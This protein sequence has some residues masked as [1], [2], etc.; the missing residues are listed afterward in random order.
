MA[1]FFKGLAGGMQS[2]L[3]LGQQLRQRRMEDELAQAYAKPQE[4][5][6]YTPEQLKQIQGLQAAGGYDVQ[7]VPGAEGAAPTLRYSARQGA[8]YY[9]DMGQPEAPIDIAPQRV[10]RYGGQTVAGQFDPA[11]L[12]GLQMREAAG[13]LGRYG[14]VRGAAALEMQAE[15]FN[16]R[17]EDR[18]YQAK[19][20]PLEMQ[21]LEGSIAGQAQ[22]RDVAA[23]QL[24]GLGRAEEKEIGFNTAFDKINSTKYETPAER[25][26]AVLTAVSQYKGPEAAAQLQAN[27]STNERNNIL[28]QGAK[29]D[30]TIKQARMKGPVAA[31][32][33]IDELNDSFTLEVDGFK[34]TQVNKDGS[35]VP[36]LQGKNA[37]EFALLV[38]SRIKDGG[39]F[40]L[41]KFRQD[42]LTKNAQIAYYN[43]LA[44]KAA[45]EGGAAANQ[46]SGVQVGYSRDPKTGQPIQVMTALRFN[47]QSGNLESV[48]VPLDQNV[49]PA[50]ALDPKKIAEQAE[51]LVNTPV[52]PTNKNKD[53]PKHT[54]LTAQQAVVDQI[55]NQ[56]LG[57]PAGG[58]DLSP[59]AIAA[60][61]ARQEKQ[62]PAAAPAASAPVGLSLGQQPPS[63]AATARDARFEQNAQAATAM[64]EREQRA[65]NDPDIRALRVQLANMRSGDPRKTA[66]LNQQIIDLRQQRY[67]F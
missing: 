44:K 17:A 50:S 30:Q 48:Q 20:R 43:S 56:Y 51:S 11:Q 8:N 18:A 25:D 59:A 47:K 34:V 65:A 62:K 22:Q 40:E 32:K 6:D 1:D 16:A 13:V 36:F 21:Q 38:D 60:E 39:A 2:G 24:R 19:R 5:T 58:L 33:A 15:D 37:D 41:A 29:F 4:F 52:D 3:Q 26:A 63:A 67:G 28:T 45:S 23:A 27:Y 64:R 66:E 12:R 46:L 49:V 14:D 57:K 31:L 7:A 9:D 35:R 54:F 10:Q 53:A 61:R 42:E 55:F